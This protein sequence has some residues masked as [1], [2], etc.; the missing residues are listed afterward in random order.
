MCTVIFVGPGA[1]ADGSTLLSHSDT[2]Q[3]SRVRRVPAATHEPGSVASLYA[4]IQDVRPDPEDFGE[5]LG[6]IPQVARTHAYLHSAYPHLNEHQLA[7]AESTTSQRPE[8]VALRGEGE[9][10][11]TIEQAM[12]LALQ[13]C[14]QAQ[15]AVELI[16]RLMEAQGFLPSCGDGGELLLLADP[17]DA[18]VMEVFGVGKGWRKDSGQPGALWAARR[19]ARDQALVVA[20]WSV[21]TELAPADPDVRI[22]RGVIE[23]AQARGWLAPGQSL[24]WRNAFTP[25]PRE[26]AL[27][28]LWLFHQRFAPSLREWP[29]RQLGPDAHQTLDA[30]VQ[31]LEPIDLYPMSIRPE[32]PLALADLMA[33]HRD[34]FAGTVYDLTAQPQWTVQDSEG[35][36][37]KS[38]LA[39]PFPG[40]ELTRLLRLTRRRPVARHFGH[41]AAISQLRS[42]RAH[43][44]AGVYWLALDNPIAAPWLPFSLATRQMP[45]P[46]RDYDPDRFSTGSLRWAVDFV[47]NLMRL[48]WQRALPLVQQRRDAFEAALQSEWLLLD[49][50]LAREPDA[51]K[52]SA[53]AT[54]FAESTVQRALQR[55]VELRHELLVQL[56]N[57][58]WV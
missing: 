1:S 36:S 14:T 55:W 22:G 53:Q 37:R 34:T 44:A 51:A 2:G 13:R 32:R 5:V 31:A 58:R 49:A 48:G 47:D 42:D 19:I 29:Q 39:T 38:E 4:G 43:D 16:G 12:A 28:R 8:L 25:L 33:F 40:P 41:Y 26:W 24:H 23:F 21:L 46:V 6:Q 17:Q 52:R 18:W 45:E 10:C 7:L 30:Y 50:A 11:L 35:K 3:D 27:S 56:T 15:E 57:N 20:N 9:G 54:A